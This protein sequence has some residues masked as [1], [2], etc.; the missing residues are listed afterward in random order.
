M[1]TTVNFAIHSKG[2]I[3]ERFLELGFNDFKSAAEFAKILPY[4]RNN[5]KENKLC[6]FN[7]FGGT[8]STKHALLKNLAI[9]NDFAEINLILGIFMMNGNNTPKISSVLKKYDLKEMPEAHNYLKYQNQ[10]LDYTRKNSSPENFIND[11]VEEIEI[12]PSQITNFK[13][14]YHRS[15]LKKY[16]HENPTITYNLYDFWQI[17]EECIIALSY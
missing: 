4:K 16:L 10:I 9:E 11:L 8:C 12:Q 3:S 6:V 17:R 5:A 14:E 15:F 7:D 13:I 2:I 1:Q